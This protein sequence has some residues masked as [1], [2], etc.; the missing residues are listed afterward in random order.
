MGNTKLKRQCEYIYHESQKFTTVIEEDM[1]AH[2]NIVA[3]LHA[4]GIKE[5]S[6][7]IV[8]NKNPKFFAKAINHATANGGH[9]GYPA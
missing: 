1:P 8:G 6:V 5:L 7:G 2:P 4:A 3:I 9:S